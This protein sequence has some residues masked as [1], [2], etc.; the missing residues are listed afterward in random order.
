MSDQVGDIVFAQHDLVDQLI[1]M[2][3]NGIYFGK[4]VM[5]KYFTEEWGEE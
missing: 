2:S 5:K 1:Q 4:N 3:A